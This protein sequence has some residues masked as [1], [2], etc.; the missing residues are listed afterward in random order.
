MAT[1]RAERIATVK[2]LYKAY[3]DVILTQPF[4]WPAW[5]G[6]MHFLLASVKAGGDTENLARSILLA[7]YAYAKC[8]ASQ[9]KPFFRAAISYVG[10]HSGAC[11]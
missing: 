11:C 2:S 7:R 6:E 10:L 5:Y 8:H 9:L 1:I 4:P 3:I